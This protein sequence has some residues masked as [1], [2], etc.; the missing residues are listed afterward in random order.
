MR[1]RF[2]LGYYKLLGVLFVT[3]AAI[4]QQEASSVP[5]AMLIAGAYYTRVQRATWPMGAAGTVLIKQPRKPALV[6]C[7]KPTKLLMPK[8]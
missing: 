6:F 1:I 7:R 2:A 4:T 8:N 5:G 3:A